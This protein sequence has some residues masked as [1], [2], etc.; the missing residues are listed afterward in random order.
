MGFMSLGGGI[1]NLGKGNFRAGS[2]F[3]RYSFRGRIAR[4][5]VL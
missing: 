3:I 5:Y 2:I 4:R 1:P